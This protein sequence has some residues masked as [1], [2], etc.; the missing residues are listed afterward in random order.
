MIALLVKRYEQLLDEVNQIEAKKFL[1][2]EKYI[3]PREQV[4]RDELLSWKVKAHSLLIKTCGEESVHVR[5]F[6]DAETSTFST[7]L[8]NL[9][10]M[11]AVFV[12]AKEDYEGGY[13]AS[14]KCLIQAEVFASELEQA[15]ELFGGGFLRAAAITSGVV[16]ETTLQELCGKYNIPRGKAARMN[17]DLPKAGAYNELKKKQVASHLA[18]RN[19]AAHSE[20]ISFGSCDVDSMITFI[21]SFIA[22]R[23][24]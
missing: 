17:D 3:S 4:N 14:T 12:A 10:R 19:E 8:N 21:E 1:E 23:W 20:K 9:R 13:L 11:R 5:E 18:I 22:E 2:P 24:G 7:S 16:L 6:V 15:K